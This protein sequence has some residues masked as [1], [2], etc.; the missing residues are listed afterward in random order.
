MNPV[1]NA[2]AVTNSAVKR[3]AKAGNSPARRG[4]VGAAGAD[5]VKGECLTGRVPI[6]VGRRWKPCSSRC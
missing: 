1:M 6:V 5:S 2:S 4:P 3:G